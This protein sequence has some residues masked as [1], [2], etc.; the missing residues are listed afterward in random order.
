[1]SQEL[2]ICPNCATKLKSGLISDI[3]IV[4]E[5]I[6]LAINEYLQLQASAHCTKCV[7]E[8]KSKYYNEISD[9]KSKNVNKIQKLLQ[10]IP[11]L[12]IQSPV[13]WDYLVLGMVTG[14]SV[15]GTGVITEFTSSFSDLFGGQS[16]RMNEK[17]KTG[18]DLCFAQL[19][20]QALDL[21]GNAVIATDIDY[22]EV[23]SVKG[24]LMVCM[25]GTAIKLTN[26]SILG[27][28]R[29]KLIE[30]LTHLNTRIKLLNVVS[31]T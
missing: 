8:F 15:T 14:Q 19:R 6:T 1:M 10:H 31:G 3:K 5:N 30:E 20:K 28:S 7:K 24:M 22:S 13:H 23:G 21:G 26:M 29:S 16:G 18:E 9:E 4:N 2:I 11:V 25:A 27:E 12:T 17:L